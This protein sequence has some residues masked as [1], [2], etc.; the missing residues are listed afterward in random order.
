MLCNC[1]GMQNRRGEF[2]TDDAAQD[3]PI[4]HVQPSSVRRT[5]AVRSASRGGWLQRG[6]ELRTLRGVDWPTRA[7]L[8]TG[9]AL[10]PCGTEVVAA[11]PPR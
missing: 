6:M 4:H 7:P 3:L 1:W 8:L 5:W 11:H 10:G 9:G 2:V